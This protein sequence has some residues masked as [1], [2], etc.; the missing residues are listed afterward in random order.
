MRRRSSPPTVGCR[1]SSPTTSPAT[2]AHH[3]R[4]NAGGWIVI[5]RGDPPTTRTP[6]V[7]AGTARRRRPFM[8]FV[9]AAGTVH[10]HRYETLD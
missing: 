5:D 3:G 6:W 10:V 2:A 8:A 9:A 4:D 7:S 1:S